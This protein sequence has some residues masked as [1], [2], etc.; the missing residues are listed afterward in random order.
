MTPGQRSGF[1]EKESSDWEDS[2]EPRSGNPRE[3]MAAP[4]TKDGQRPA[5][6]MASEGSFPA[7][8]VNPLVNRPA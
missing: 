5:Q 1:N 4:G 7:M 8:M 2:R 6:A 3:W